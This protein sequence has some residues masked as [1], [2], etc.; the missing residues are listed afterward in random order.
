MPQLLFAHEKI[1][2]EIPSGLLIH[3]GDGDVVFTG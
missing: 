3:D 1:A 2:S